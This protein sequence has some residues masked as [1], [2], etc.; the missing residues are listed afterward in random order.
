MWPRA[1][2]R[3]NAAISNGERPSKLSP[4]ILNSILWVSKKGEDS[5]EKCVLIFFFFFLSKKRRTIL[6]LI[7]NFFNK[8]LNFVRRNDARFENWLLVNVRINYLFL[9]Q[10][11]ESRKWNHPQILLEKNLEIL[12]WN[13][14]SEHFKIY[15][16]I[17]NLVQIDNWRTSE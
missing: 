9:I 14:F 11:I 12:P 4:T 2:K 13:L 5:I 1:K 17:Y 3:K 6:I 16:L 7:D 8:V 15:N 10:I